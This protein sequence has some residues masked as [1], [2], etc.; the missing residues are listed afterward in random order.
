MRK[1]N[2]EYFISDRNI[3]YG[4]HV[5][6][7]AYDALLGLMHEMGFT[8]IYIKTNEDGEEQFIYPSEL[9]EGYF[10]PVSQYKIKEAGKI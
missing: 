5:G 7:S 2:R 4:I 8:D 3:D 1:Q 9:A 6:Y 10:E